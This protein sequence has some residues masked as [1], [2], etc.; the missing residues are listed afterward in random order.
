MS[1]GNKK[2]ICALT[3]REVKP[4]GKSN[5]DDHH[6]GGEDGE[7]QDQHLVV[8]MH[9]GHWTPADQIAANYLCRLCYI[10]NEISS[11]WRALSLIRL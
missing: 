1:N 10:D 11:M 5:K 7:A 6:P 9:G 2:N 4:D 8:R 3:M